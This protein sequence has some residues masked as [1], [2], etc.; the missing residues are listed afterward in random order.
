MVAT[1]RLRR[2]DDYHVH[3]RGGAM[4]RLVLPHTVQQFARAIIMPNA[5]SITDFNT[6]QAYRTE[7]YKL[8][9]GGSF[10]P[11]M[12]LKLTKSTTPEL[13]TQVSSIIHAVKFYPA[14][15]TT[16]S[17]DGLTV[18]EFLQM[19]AVFD[20]MQKLGIV[21]SIHGEY[22]GPETFCLDRE[23]RILGWIS[24]I[25]NGYPKLRIVMEHITTRYA[26]EWVAAAPANVGATITAH[27]LYLTLNDVVG[28]GEVNGF[29][30]LQPHHYCL[31]VAKRADDR[32]ALLTAIISGNPK[33][34]FGSDSAPHTRERKHWDGCAGVF[35]AAVALPALA[36]RLELFDALDKLEAFTSVNGAVFYGISLNRDYIELRREPWAVRS[37]VG[38]GDLCVANFLGG[39][40]LNWQLG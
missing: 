6:L 10:Q 20:T 9:N 5:P 25:V 32:T 3:L 35:T 33:F 15:V 30:G 34:F 31:P 28:G 8:L 27:H 23:P 12:T 4:L 40:F 14:N 11:L 19:D 16:G 18:E 17:D 29:H 1:I 24:K 39:Q 26:V 13:L 38:D 36:H 37:A 7:I 2:P 21:L 22:P